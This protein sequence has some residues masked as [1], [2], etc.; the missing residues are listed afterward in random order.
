[1]RKVLG[2]RT[3]KRKK[4]VENVAAGEENTARSLSVAES[5]GR[6]LGDMGSGERLW[7][8]VLGRVLGDWWVFWG[9]RR[10]FRNGNK[11]E[12]GNEE[13]ESSLFSPPLPVRSAAQ[14]RRAPGA[15]TTIVGFTVYHVFSNNRSYDSPVSHLAQSIHPSIIHP[16]YPHP[17]PHPHTHPEPVIIP[18]SA[19]RQPPFP[20]QSRPTP[21]I[22]LE[23]VT[24]SC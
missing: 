3:R 18:P 21:R 20:P 23:P 2:C 22:L 5:L 6:S 10:R 13:A 24:M 1:M 15:T 19:G 16:C 11:K 8:W 7:G 9:P 17:H 4:N 12:R 14:R